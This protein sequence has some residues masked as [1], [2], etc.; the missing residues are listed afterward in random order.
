VSL[1]AERAYECVASESVECS[2]N[3]YCAGHAG[4][5]VFRS[6]PR[7]CRD[8]AQN[9]TDGTTLSVPLCSPHLHNFPLTQSALHAFLPAS[10]AV[11]RK[12]LC[13]TFL[14][15]C[16]SNRDSNRII[17]ISAD[18]IADDLQIASVVM[19]T[20]VLTG[21]YFVQS[22]PPWISWMKC[23]ALTIFQSDACTLPYLTHIHAR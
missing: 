5:P 21:G 12:K 9:S 4:V 3:S 10:I 8:G 17:L 2:G 14:M 19:L 7:D 23:A 15:V 22:I 16:D 6:A 13:H 18:F 1:P 20:F 11:L